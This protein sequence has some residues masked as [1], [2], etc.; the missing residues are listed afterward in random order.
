MLRQARLPVHST[1]GQRAKGRSYIVMRAD[2]RR[3]NECCSLVLSGAGHDTRGAS[4]CYSP[5]APTGQHGRTNGP[6]RDET[7]LIRLIGTLRL[8]SR[9]FLAKPLT[10]RHDSPRSVSISV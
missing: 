4:S 1:A 10:E 8:E 7:T 5:H 3:L 9:R 6:F 2:R